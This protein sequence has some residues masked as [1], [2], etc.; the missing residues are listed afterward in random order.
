MGK[1]QAEQPDAN[2]TRRDVD[3]RAIAERALR[4]RG[5][6]GGD[7]ALVLRS[8]GDEVVGHVR[9]RLA[10]GGLEPVEVERFHRSDAREDRDPRRDREVQLHRDD[11]RD[12]RVRA[13][14]AQQRPEG[15]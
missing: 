3:E 6:I 8:A 14:D 13:H 11:E 15:I 5:A 7:A 9:E 1:R 12:A 10:G 2:V 4:E